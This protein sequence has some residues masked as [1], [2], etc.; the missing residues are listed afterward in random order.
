MLLASKTKTPVLG[1]KAEALLNLKNAGF[2]IPPSYFSPT[3][4]K[5]AVSDLGFPLVVRSSATVEDGQESSFAGQFESYLNLHSVE[6]VEEAFQKCV[7]SIQAPSVLE[8]CKKNGVDS[9]SIEMGVIV[10][11]MIQPEL[12][13]VAFSIN[14]ITGSEEVIIE[15][16]P[17]L[18]DRLLAGQQ[19]PLPEDDLLIQKYRPQIEQLAKDFGVEDFGG[20]KSWS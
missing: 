8:Y 17:G 6:D 11:R 7:D 20:C 14:P 3:D 12:A 10:Q 13:G 2:D 16:V 5:A 9:E 4:L 1:G 19:E 18:A 15:A